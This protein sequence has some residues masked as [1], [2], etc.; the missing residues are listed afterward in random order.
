MNF[1]CGSS[2]TSADLLLLGLIVAAIG[3]RL[4]IVRRHTVL[5][6]PIILPETYC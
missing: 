2:G 6:D 5:G 1:R 4:K 3:I